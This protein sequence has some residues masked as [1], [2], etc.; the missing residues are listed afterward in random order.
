MQNS[1]FSQAYSFREL[2]FIE[3]HHIDLPYGLKYNCIGYIIKGQ[4]DIEME[5][6]TLRL[7]PGDIYQIPKGIKYRSRWRGNPEISFKVFAYLN[8]PGEKFQTAK[9]QKIKNTPRIIELIN[10]I[11][12]NNVIDCYSV[13]RFY[14]LL[15]EIIKDVESSSLSKEQLLL[16]K[17]MNFISENPDCL[18]PEVASYCNMSESSFYNLFKKHSK[19]TPTKYR[20]GVK[21]DNAFELIVSTDMPIEQISEVCGFS[22]SSYFRKHFYKKYGK[23]PS[24]IRKESLI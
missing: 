23:T 6:Q 10:K 7:G 20:V 19:I 4:L 9:L 12:T 18:M 13:G 16:N 15:D 2:N 24:R 5:N 22:S 8:Y 21:L 1:T 11:P 17:A 14:L 3:S